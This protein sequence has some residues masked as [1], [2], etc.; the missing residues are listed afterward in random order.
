[1]GGRGG[2]ESDSPP[3]GREPIGVISAL[4]GL[5]CIGVVA[6]LLRWS[7]WWPHSD[8]RQI[9]GTACGW[10]TGAFG[11]MTFMIAL[12]RFSERDRRLL[13]VSAVL[14]TTV[15]LTTGFWILKSLTAWAR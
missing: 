15:G 11:L 4:V 3:P 6:A 10:L 14:V 8:M 5:G 9:W 1:M 12:S 13:V 2:S 7:W